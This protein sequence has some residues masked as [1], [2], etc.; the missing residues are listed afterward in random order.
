MIL[1]ET[2][3]ILHSRIKAF[4]RF[5]KGPQGWNMWIYRR[6]G[7]CSFQGQEGWPAPAVLTFRFQYAFE[8]GVRYNNL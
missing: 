3:E 8:D 6:A 1:A 7:V 5:L 4:S 2:Y